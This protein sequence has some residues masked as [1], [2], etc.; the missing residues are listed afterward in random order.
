MVLASE[1]LTQTSPPVS[2]GTVRAFTVTVAEVE[3]VQLSLLVIA[4]VTV[5][6][7]ASV[8]LAVMLEVP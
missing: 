2:S 5:L 7:P 6:L 8:Q 1:V 4:T 3:A